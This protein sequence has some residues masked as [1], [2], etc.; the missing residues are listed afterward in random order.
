MFNLPSDLQRYIW[1]FDSTYKYHYEDKVIPLLD[2]QWQ[3]KYVHKKSGIYGLDMSHDLSDSLLMWDDFRNTKA[4]YDLCNVTV[5]SYKKALSICLKLK[6]LYPHFTFLPEHKTYGD[7]N[8]TY[9]I[10]KYPYLFLSSQ[11]YKKYN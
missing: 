4:M 10:G 5:Y 3:I 8:H 6:K 1:T 7:L 11:D 9:L 2:H